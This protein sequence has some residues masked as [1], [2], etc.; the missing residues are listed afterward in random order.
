METQN[1]N[2]GG[3]ISYRASYIKREGPQVKSLREVGG[4]PEPS[5]ARPLRGFNAPSPQPRMTAP[6]HSRHSAERSV[7]YHARIMGQD[8]RLVDEL[9]PTKTL[10]ASRSFPGLATG[11]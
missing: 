11:E 6:S 5:A 4:L 10:K 1:R 3:G 7:H 8:P 9:N 2:Q